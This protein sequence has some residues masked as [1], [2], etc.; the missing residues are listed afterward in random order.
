MLA[1]DF[2]HVDTVLLRRIYVFFVIELDSRRVHLVGV[3]KHPTGE[4]VT[5][6]AR[7]FLIDMGERVETF[8]FLIRGPRH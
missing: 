1:C 4:W 2:A 8:R 3:T 7:N 6:A 5:Q